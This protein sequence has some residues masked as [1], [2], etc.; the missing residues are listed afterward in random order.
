MPSLGLA[1]H[2]WKK[3]GS[4]MGLGQR[5]YFETMEKAW[6]SIR[7]P[8]ELSGLS[9]ERRMQADDLRDEILAANPALP[10]GSVSLQCD[11][12]GDFSEVRICLS[13]NLDGRACPTNTGRGCPRTLTILPPP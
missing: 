11:R 1:A 10:R 7:I 9:G 8:A 4:C 5:G 13:G 6:R 12:E 2:E 3:H